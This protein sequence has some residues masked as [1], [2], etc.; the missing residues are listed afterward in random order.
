MTELIEKKNHEPRLSV[1]LVLSIK[2]RR[3][4]IQNL[5]FCVFFFWQAFYLLFDKGSVWIELIVAENL[6]LK[7]EN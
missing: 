5:A 2:I 3:F 1:F 4:V 7:T 6:K